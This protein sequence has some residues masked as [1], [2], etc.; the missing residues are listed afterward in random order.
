M[1]RVV[2]GCASGWMMGGCVAA[3]WLTDQKEDGGDEEGAHHNDKCGPTPGC[4][5]GVGA[6]LAFGLGVRR[7]VTFLAQRAQDTRAVRAAG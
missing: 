1:A 2:T 6:L 5:F 3:G 4:A 7:P